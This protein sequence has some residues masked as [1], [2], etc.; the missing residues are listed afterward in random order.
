MG[1]PAGPLVRSLVASV[2]A[3]MAVAETGVCKA[4]AESAGSWCRAHGAQRR[5]HDP[6]DCASAAPRGN[7]PKHPARGLM[8]SAKDVARLGRDPASR[9]FRDLRGSVSASLH[10]QRRG[11]HAAILRVLPMYDVQCENPHVGAAFIMNCLGGES[12]PLRPS[13]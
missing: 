3:T 10:C 11:R 4:Q 8:M 13:L 5:S 2:D 9:R 12:L 7:A 6:A 1:T